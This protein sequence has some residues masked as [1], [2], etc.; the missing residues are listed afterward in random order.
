M[1]PVR[2]RA[3]RMPTEAAE[4][5]M[6]PVNTAP[7]T[8]PRKGLVKAVRM[9]ANSG[10]SARGLTAFFIRSMP[11]IS[12]AKPTMMDPA[13]RGRL[14]LADMVRMTPARATTG[15]KT[16]GL[17][18]FSHTASPSMPDRER[19]QAVRV[20]PTLEPIMIP[21]VCPSCMMPEFT[22]PTSMTVI[23]EED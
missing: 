7:T 15:E 10:M 12:T 13:L 4:D 6:I 19:I 17:S 11:V 21:T 14:R 1:P 2:D 5:W 23:A 8:T 3:W 20:V 22:R 9:E 18:S 16:S